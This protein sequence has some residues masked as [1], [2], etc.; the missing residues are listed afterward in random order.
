MTLKRF[1]F[2][3]EGGGYND[4]MAHSKAEAIRLG[5]EL[6]KPSTDMPWKKALIVD[7]ST[8][9][10]APAAVAAYNRESNLWD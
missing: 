3:W 2:N 4:V 8:I 1:V 7:E 9:S 5:N 6:G 10:S